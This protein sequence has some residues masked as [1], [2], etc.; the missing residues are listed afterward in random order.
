MTAI[1]GV[2][3]AV[4]RRIA[5]KTRAGAPA[6][7]FAGPGHTAV[8]VVRADALA[9]TN[10]FVMLMDDRLDFHPGQPV[11][12]AHP[13]AGLETVTL[14][15]EGSLD[16]PAEGGLL[17]AG[18]VA[19]M[20]AGRGI[21]HSEDVK[22]TG[23][24]RILQLWLMLPRTARDSDPELQLVPL[25]TLPVRREPGVEARLYSGSTGTLRSPTRNRVPVT[26]VDFTL[27][28]DATVTQELPGAYTAFLYVVDGSVRVGDEVLVTGEIGWLDRA[29]Q[30][31]THLRLSA[32][33]AGARVILYAGE[34][35]NEPLVQRG[36]FVAGTPAEISAY[37]AAYRAGAF[38]RLSEVAGRPTTARAD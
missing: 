12:E 2:M 6:A 14:I 10:P 23:W 11:G 15:L 25:S 33:A 37:Y 32:E 29:E 16:D 36:P 27:A 7:G 31:V 22:A 24:A 13:H 30:D 26:M 8:E 3:P 5:R 17:H 9:E 28:P 35:Q 34:P 4:A 20:T 38:P 1:S 21:V 19:W 18:D